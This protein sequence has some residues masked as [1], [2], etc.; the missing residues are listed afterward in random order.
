MRASPMNSQCE[1]EAK[2]KRVCLISVTETP[3]LLSRET[4]SDHEIRLVFA[5]SRN[6]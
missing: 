1:M 3:R 6:N 2:R 4:Q 5:T